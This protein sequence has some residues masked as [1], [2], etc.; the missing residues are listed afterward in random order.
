MTLMDVDSKDGI[1]QAFTHGVCPELPRGIAP[2]I[3]DKTIDNNHN[4]GAAD[5]FKMLFCE[6]KLLRRPAQRLWA[7]SLLPMLSWILLPSEG[8]KG[9]Q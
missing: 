7:A 3:K 6:L 8:M 2:F 9:G 4:S 5:L 1:K